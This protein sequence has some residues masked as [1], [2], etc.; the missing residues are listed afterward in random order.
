MTRLGIEPATPDH[1]AD[2]LP[3]SHCAGLN[4]SVHMY[5]LIWFLYYENKPIQI[6]WKFYQQ[7]MKIF[8]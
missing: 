5:M 1:K 8:R 7:K 6:Y 3:L 2:A 4:K